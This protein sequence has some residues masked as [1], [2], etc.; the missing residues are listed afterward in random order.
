MT[1]Q[2]MP[3]TEPPLL[4]KAT[5][6]TEQSSIDDQDIDD[7]ILLKKI[8]N[9]DSLLKS[10]STLEDKKKS[11]WLEIY[12]NSIFDRKH[13]FEQYL[14][15]REICSNKSSEHA[16]HGKSIATYLER[17]SRANDQLIKL[18]DMVASAEEKVIKA[19]ETSANDVYN[20]INKKSSKV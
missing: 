16:V 8:K 6:Q 2:D 11:L 5:D 4:T 13:A 14:L 9:F 12:Q 3:P 20:I 7:P 17:M 15:L 19:N 18:A 10:I 1:I